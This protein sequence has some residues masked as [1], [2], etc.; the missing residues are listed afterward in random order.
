MESD[1]PSDLDGL[2]ASCLIPDKGVEAGGTADAEGPEPLSGDDIAVSGFNL[3]A[4]A[5]TKGDETMGAEAASTRLEPVADVAEPLAAEDFTVSG[6]SWD[7][8]PQPQHH[9]PSGIVTVLDA[10]EPVTEEPDAPAPPYDEVGMKTNPHIDGGAPHLVIP[11]ERQESAT[12]PE[13]RFATNPFSIQPEVALSRV[14]QYLPGTG[15][16][17]LAIIADYPEAGSVRTGV[18][19]WGDGHI[20]RM[21]MRALEANGFT[22]AATVAMSANPADELIRE[23]PLPNIRSAAITYVSNLQ[24]AN[25]RCAVEDILDRRNVDRLR[26]FLSCAMTRCPDQLRIVT[27][28]PVAKFAFKGLNLEFP[29]GMTIAS[30]LNPAVEV[31]K[32]SFSMDAW[33]KWATTAFHTD[34]QPTSK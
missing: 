22:D 26:S 32:P 18:P 27:M 23:C 12:S 9:A 30:I 4:S 5:K 29:N 3:D 20:G 11:L 25:R 34:L 19:F 13:S 28:G 15:L 21:V 24:D 16:I 2:T 7:A 8:A 33:V 31:K 14:P 1:H 17:L 10:G 6:L